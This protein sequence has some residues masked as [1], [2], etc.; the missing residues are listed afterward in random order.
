L[1][2]IVAAKNPV[3]GSV[4]L[5]GLR[6]VQNIRSKVKGHS[7]SSEGKTMAQDAL[8]KHGTYGEHFKHL[9]ELIVHDLQRVE[10]ALGA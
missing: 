1:E 7:G 9:C 5:K 6:T 4:T 2:K 10:S 8:A 3:V